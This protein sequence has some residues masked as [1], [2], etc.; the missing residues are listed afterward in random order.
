LLPKSRFFKIKWPGNQIFTTESTQWLM[1]T[2]K[3]RTKD[4]NPGGILPDQ[5]DSI[6]LLDNNPHVAIKNIH[7]Q[8]V[9]VLVS[10]V[11]MIFFC[12]VFCSAIKEDDH[13]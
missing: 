5:S 8:K 12:G 4:L 11:L 6:I 7:M 13:G 1:M 3:T 10:I 2:E 9:R